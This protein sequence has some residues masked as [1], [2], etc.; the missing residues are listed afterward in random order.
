MTKG[1]V[2]KTVFVNGLRIVSETLLDRDSVAIGVWVEVGSRH[3][4]PDVAGVSHFLEHMVFKGTQTRSAREIALS[5]ERLGGMLNA[6]TTREHTCYHARILGEN[7]PQA[8]DV[9]A[10]LATR[11]RL[12]AAEVRKERKVIAEEIKDVQ[13]TAHEH[14]HDLFAE[15]VWPGHPI[16][17]PVAG[18]LETVAA[19]TRAALGSH[20]RAFYRPDRIVVAASGGLAHDH[21]TRLVRR[22]F[23][24]PRPTSPARPMA[25]PDGLAPRRGVNA[26]DIKQTHVCIGVPTWAFADRRRYATL[27]TNSVL[28][29]GMSSRLFQTVRERRGLVYTISAF[30][31]SFQDTGFFAVYFA[32]DPRQVVKAINLVL[33]EMGRLS[34]QTVPPVELHD[35]KSQ[36][37]GNLLLGLE[38][39]SAR[40]HRLAR[41]ELYLGRQIPPRATMKAIEGV[42]AAELVALAREAFTPDR[43]ALSILGPVDEAVLDQIDWNKLGVRARRRG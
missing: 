6:F 28:G 40:M 43:V 4:E 33:A 25:S 9:L 2:A 10:D 30:H 29:G 20:R 36:L 14:I 34:R 21:L 42:R 38:S 7:L 1:R 35:A 26:R 19:T 31:D 16:G 15:Q 17:R 32:C 24:L 3:E 5:L 23:H 12:P 11:A 41:H 8:V 37:R 13:D 27:V 18:T 22:H 39:T